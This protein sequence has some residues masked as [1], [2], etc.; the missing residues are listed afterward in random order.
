MSFLGWLYLCEGGEEV[1]DVTLYR[2]RGG[3][4][5]LVVAGPCEGYG[6]ALEE[7]GGW[8]QRYGG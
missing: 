6:Y 5:G 8:C 7:K 4:F 1:V 2:I 3:Y